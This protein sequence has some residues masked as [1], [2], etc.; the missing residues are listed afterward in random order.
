[1]IIC[2]Y[3]YILFASSNV[4]YFYGVTCEKTA[5]GVAVFAGFIDLF[6]LSL[7]LVELFEDNGEAGDEGIALG[8]GG[9]LQIETSGFGQEGETMLVLDLVDQPR[10]SSQS[11]RLFAHIH[12]QYIQERNG[13][14]LTLSSPHT[15]SLPQ[16]CFWTQS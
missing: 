7:E 4:S 16:E 14:H 8:L 2:D 6:F 15:F 11:R 3:Y 13:A 1:L 9:S 5:S 10:V 12:V